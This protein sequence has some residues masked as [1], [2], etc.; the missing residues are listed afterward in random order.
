IGYRPRK[1][2]PDKFYYD[3][4]NVPILHKDYAGKYDAAKFFLNESLFIVHAAISRGPA[5]AAAMKAGLPPPKVQSVTNL[6][7]MN[8]SEPGMVAAAGI[9]VRWV[10]SVDDTFGATGPVSGIEWQEDFEYYL[11]LL[12]EGL[13]K[14]KP[15][16]LNV[17]R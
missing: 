9:W 17:F 11:Q 12:T 10:Y 13:Q 15:S 4:T 6:W 7:G 3:S 2:N 5:T 14:K 1:K 16:I 8:H